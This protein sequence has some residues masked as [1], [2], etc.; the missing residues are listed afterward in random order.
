MSRKPEAPRPRAPRAS[1]RHGLRRRPHDA[2]LAR[3][4]R[5]RDLALDRARREAE[6]IS[7]ASHEIRTPLHGIMGFSTLLLSTELTDEQRSFANALHTSIES[8]LAVVNDVLDVSTLDAGA[9]R[10]ESVRFNLLTLVRGLVDTFG[11]AAAAKGLALRVDT[12]AV[13]HPHLVGDPG[14]VRQ[15][16][17][18][19]V[20]NAVKFTDAGEVMVRAVTRAT[21]AGT[22]EVEVSVTDT[23]RG[24]PRHA[25]ARLFQPFSRLQQPGLA[26]APGTGLGLSISKQLV[27]LMGGAVSVKSSP[28]RG[29]TFQFT[30]CLQEDIVP[31]A[32]RDLE[33]GTAGRLRVYV[34]DDDPRSLSELLLSLAAVGVSVAG[35]GSAAGLPEAL[36]TTRAQGHPPGVAIVGHVRHQGGDLAIARAVKADPRLTGVPLVLAPVSG[37]RGYA[38]EVREAGYSAYVPRPFQGDELLQCLCAAVTQGQDGPVDETRLITRHNVS[39]DPTSAAAGRVLVADDDPASRQVVRLQVARLGYL[40]DDVSGGREAVAAAATGHYQLI[41]MDCQM[42]DMDGLSATA[43][44]RRHERPGHH[45]HI[46]ALTADVSADQRARCRQAGMDEFLEKPLRTQTLA[47]LLNRHLRRGHDALALEPP[48]GVGRRDESPTSGIDVLEAEIG[49]EMTRDLVR[50]YLAGVEQAIARLTQAD[51]LDAGDV[52]S[53]AHRLLGGARVLGLVRLERL[54]AALSEHADDAGNS[55]PPALLDDLRAASTELGAW[56]DSCQRKQH[57]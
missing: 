17:A 27:E 54:W 11:Q 6:F 51:G 20:S 47:A 25:Q 4:R 44:I 33:P 21:G 42:P 55:V 10:L 43:A 30:V 7:H 57:A 5:E 26:A 2:T 56:F 1:V 52:R 16:L 3:L 46:V 36:R 41:L 39:E 48:A 45:T 24:I 12:T 13:K 53:A 32:P 38:R 28:G 19:F 22:A 14:R 23:G 8:L 35:S 50:E 49:H 29:S 40:V 31:S 15:V 34:A 9:M 18:N 37:I